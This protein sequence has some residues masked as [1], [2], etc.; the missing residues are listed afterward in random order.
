MNE[1]LSHSGSI[2]WHRLE[3]E[4]LEAGEPV[5]GPWVLVLRGWQWDGCKNS[6]GEALGTWLFPCSLHLLG[7]TDHSLNSGK[8]SGQH[9][10]LWQLGQMFFQS[11]CPPF[12][13]EHSPARS[14]E[15]IVICIWT[16]NSIFWNSE[17][18]PAGVSWAPS[19]LQ[20]ACFNLGLGG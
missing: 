8:V 14:R 5:Q 4:I 10:S 15:E 17:Q 16:W 7:S 3:K 6:C 20:P 9:N 13:W 18:G 19:Q 2:D 1:W 11:P 12:R